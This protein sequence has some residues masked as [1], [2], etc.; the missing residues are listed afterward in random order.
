MILV[1]LLTVLTLFVSPE[2]MLTQ[3]RAAPKEMLLKNTWISVGAC[4]VVGLLSHMVVLFL[5]F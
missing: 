5:V 4:P 3:P 2:T 1:M